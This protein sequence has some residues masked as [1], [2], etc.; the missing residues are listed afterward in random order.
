M[1]TS[2]EQRKCG[3]D[4]IK[5]YRGFA[6]STGATQCYGISNS[7]DYLQC[8]VDTVDQVSKAIDEMSEAWY[9]VKIGGDRDPVVEEAKK[10]TVAC[11]EGRGFK[12]IDLDLLFYWQ[13][14]TARRSTRRERPNCLP[15]RRM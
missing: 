10:D 4:I 12:N 5:E 3:E 2:Q 7:D 6:L 14:S 8:R 1:T 9:K 11:L 13:R 15:K